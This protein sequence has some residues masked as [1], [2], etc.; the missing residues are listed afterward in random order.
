MK[1]AIRQ[2][3]QTHNIQ[4]QRNVEH[5]R[6]RLNM[7]SQTGREPCL[8]A[9]HRTVR[10]IGDEIKRRVIEGCGNTES[11]ADGQVD[12]IVGNASG[13]CARTSASGLCTGQDVCLCVARMCMATAILANLRH[14]DRHLAFV[15]SSSSEGSPCPCVE[16][17]TLRP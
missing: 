9:P 13:L 4:S 11:N 14:H 2:D 8:R 7:S 1:N 6:K 15:H 10:R 12:R 3:I 16:L 5:G 17:P